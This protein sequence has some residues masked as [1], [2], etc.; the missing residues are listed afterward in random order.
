MATSDDR[1]YFDALEHAVKAWGKWADESWKVVE[2]RS[3]LDRLVT[4]MGSPSVRGGAVADRDRKPFYIP[5]QS[6]QYVAVT[7][8]GDMGLQLQTG[9]MQ[10]VRRIG[11]EWQLTERVA[12]VSQREKWYKRPFFDQSCSDRPRKRRRRSSV[13]VA[14]R[15]G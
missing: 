2:A 14:A 8:H 6:W 5:T 11:P 12:P 15:Q 4:M 13:S 1:T 7:W 9:F 3:A 10:A